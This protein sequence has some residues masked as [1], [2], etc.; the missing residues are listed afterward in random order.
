MCIHTCMWIHVC[1]CMFVCMY[2]YICV[3]NYICVS[4]LPFP[5]PIYRLLIV[6]F[7]LSL[8]LQV[9]IQSASTLIQSCG[10]R[11]WPSARPMSR[12]ALVRTFYINRVYEIDFEFVIFKWLHISI[13]EQVRV[14]DR[15]SK[16]FSTYCHP[17]AHIYIHTHCHP[18][19][20]IH[21][22]TQY[23]Y[24]HIYTHINTYSRAHVHVQ[25]YACTHVHMYTYTHVH[26]RIRMCV[27]TIWNIQPVQHARIRTQTVKW[28]VNVNENRALLRRKRALFQK[29]RAHFRENGAV[30]QRKQNHM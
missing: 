12:T 7:A 18:Q 17:Q 8:S 16:Y 21:M 15:T 30:V 22:H 2:I 10:A 26:I 27:W 28:Y 19:A 25:I 3:H 13:W 4:C 6:L 14:T 20:H 11:F 24:V 1:V 29:N 5:L 23:L 9:A